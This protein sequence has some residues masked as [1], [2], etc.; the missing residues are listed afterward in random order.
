VK[1]NA[2]GWSKRCKEE[3]LPLKQ[4]DNNS[5]G[6]KY[7]LARIAKGEA[8]ARDECR[9]E[10]YPYV[11]RVVRK[12]CAPCSS[13]L[14]VEDC[15]LDVFSVFF[16]EVERRAHIFKSS[17]FSDAEKPRHPVHQLLDT[18]VCNTL[19]DKLSDKDLL[20]YFDML[21]GDDSTRDIADRAFAE[22]DRRHR[23]YLMYIC[24]RYAHRIFD[25]MQIEE[26][27]QEI[28]I[29]ISLKAH[30]YKDNGLQ[31]YEQL[32]RRTRS[33]LAVIA[34]NCY[35]DMLEG[36]I[37][38]EDEHIDDERYA[39][40]PSETSEEEDLDEEF[41]ASQDN[42]CL[43]EALLKVLNKRQ[44]V[45]LQISYDYYES[46]EEKEKTLKKL[47]ES[48]AITPANLRTIRSRAIKKLKIYLSG[49]SKE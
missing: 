3:R 13:L 43:R 49:L 31:D 38:V 6:R 14:N 30:T 45:I 17:D 1:G 48:L 40:F 42:I 19:S 28:F 27:V 26:L 16:Q 47:A 12:Y 2:G 18:A 36:R 8:A 10:F 7:L 23:S 37:S 9:R 5:W 39:Q 24:G 4:G 11:K 20:A 21:K 35:I 46:E 41:P 22:F 44:R 29:R 32:R 34:R 25:Q 33:W 15:V